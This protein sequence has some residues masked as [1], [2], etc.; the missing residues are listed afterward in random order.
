MWLAAATTGSGRS[1]TRLSSSARWP[2]SRVCSPGGSAG[3]ASASGSPRWISA[4]SAKKMWSRPAK[5]QC[6]A[7]G[8]AG[9]DSGSATLVPGLVVIGYDVSPDADHAD[10]QLGRDPRAQ[11]DRR[12]QQLE[13][14]RRP[15]AQP[16]ADLMRVRRAVTIQQS[17]NDRARGSPPMFTALP[18]TQLEKRAPATLEAR[19]LRSWRQAVH[20]LM[21]SDHV[22][23]DPSASLREVARAMRDHSWPRNEG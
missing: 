8:V 20:E 19:S 13:Q 17:A 14:R 5:Y 16:D 11:Q 22:V 9:E 4:S 6:S 1:V 15:I 2:I 23:V 18:A 3:G 10:R 12:A 7:G 21:T